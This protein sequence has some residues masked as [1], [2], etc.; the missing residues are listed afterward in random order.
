MQFCHATGIDQ[1]G[2]PIELGSCMVAALSERTM[3]RTRPRRPMTGKRQVERI[4]Q[5]VSH[6]GPSIRVTTRLSSQRK[7]APCARPARR[8]D[9]VFRQVSW[10][11][12]LRSPPP[13][14]TLRRKGQWH[15]GEGL[16]A[17]SCGGSFGLDSPK[18]NRTE[19]PFGRP[20]RP[21]HLN[22]LRE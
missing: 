6:S 1:R 9:D 20:T 2:P 10:L 13:S 3:R 14:Q 4:A 11:A 8:K 15:F 12:G 21:A 17:D 19:F 5:K 7:T 16:A 18:A 22:G